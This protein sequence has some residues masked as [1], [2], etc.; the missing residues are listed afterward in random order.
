MSVENAKKFLDS[1]KKN[2]LV[3]TQL[4]NISDKDTLAKTAVKLG[5][6]MGYEFT[7]EEVKKVLGQA[8]GKLSGGDLGD[9]AGGLF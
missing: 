7:E 3:K 4:E 2:P 6:Q 5:K 9:L 8:D 1:V